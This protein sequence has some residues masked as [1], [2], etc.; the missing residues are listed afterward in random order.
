MPAINSLADFKALQGAITAV[1]QVTSG[2]FAPGQPISVADFP[3]VSVRE[4]DIFIGTQDNDVFNGGA[5]DDRIFGNAGDDFINPGDNNGWD[6]FSTGSGNDTVDMSDIVTG[7]VETDYSF[8]DGTGTGIVATL[9]GA[10]NTGT[11]NKGTFGTDTYIGV[12]NPFDAGW[13]TGGFGIGGSAQNDV[14]NITTDSEQWM[15]VGAS[16]GNDTINAS[17]DGSVRANYAGGGPVVADLAAGT[18]TANGFTDTVSGLWEIRASDFSD[19]ITGSGADESFIL[20]QGNDTVDGGG[21]FD[22]LR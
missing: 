11:V 3:G 21:G 22:R 5:G 17:G 20:Q 10:T 1:G 15:Q 19:N 12:S 4:D 16:A 8:L 2:P 6:F 18:I 14:F 7:Y 13:T 9:N